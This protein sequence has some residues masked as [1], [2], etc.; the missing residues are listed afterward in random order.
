MAVLSWSESWGR[1]A[2][3]RHLCP[4]RTVPLR[5]RRKRRRSAAFTRRTV[6]CVYSFPTNHFRRA[7]QDLRSAYRRVRRQLIAAPEG[8]A[9]LAGWSPDG[10][11]LL[12]TSSDLGNEHLWA[13]RVQDGRAQGQPLSLAKGLP[14]ASCQGHCRRRDHGVH[15][16][17]ASGSTSR[18][19]IHLPAPRAPRGM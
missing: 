1:S 5:F 12:F 15:R 13:V 8:G 4:A 17:L 6:H 14:R 9:M 11:Y 7:G 10:R 3:D 18:R 16:G 2:F 19:L